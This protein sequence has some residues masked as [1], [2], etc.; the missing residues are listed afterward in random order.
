MAVA[1]VLLVAGSLYV[2]VSAPARD[3]AVQPSPAAQVR[4]SAEGP[5]AEEFDT[6]ARGAARKALSAATLAFADLGSFDG[7]SPQ[8]LAMIEPSLDFTMDPSE[9]GTA[10]VATDGRWFAVAMRS[11]SGTCWWI[12]ERGADGRQRFGTGDACTGADA[13]RGATDPAW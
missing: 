6:R 7:V 9:Q 13:L 12:A 8:L 4:P 1:L 11:G 10:S 2:V 5:S 3:R